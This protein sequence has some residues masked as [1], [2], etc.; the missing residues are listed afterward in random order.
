MKLLST[1]AKVILKNI[2]KRFLSNCYEWIEDV[3]SVELVFLASPTQCKLFLIFRRC[4]LRQAVFL[5]AL[6][7]TVCG[8]APKALATG[9]T[10]HY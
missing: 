6:D 7:E 3:E 8:A 4:F 9:L 5:T 2:A 1:G 10:S